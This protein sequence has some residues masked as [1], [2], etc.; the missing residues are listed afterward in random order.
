MSKTGVRRPGLH[1]A[2]SL[3]VGV[4][5]LVAVLI[6]V[7]IMDAERAETTVSAALIGIGMFAAIMG[8]AMSSV[9]LI[10]IKAYR[11]VARG[12]NAIARWTVS[13]D[14]LDAFRAG[15]ARRSAHGPE[16][17]SDYTPPEVCPHGGLDVIFVANAVMI[18]GQFFGLSNTGLVRFDALKMLRQGMLGIEFRIRYTTVHGA[19]VQR[20]QTDTILLRVPVATAALEDAERVHSHFEKVLRREIIVNPGF[21]VF[22][23]KL[24]LWTA[25]IFGMAAAL[26]YSFW[27]PSTSLENPVPEIMMG[28]GIVFAGAGLILALGAW[29]QYRRQHRRG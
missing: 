19:T 29:I 25:A 1:A 5:G 9:F 2:I 3:S 18:G 17:L 16:Y 24:G 4:G 14:E 26:G 21:W 23:I 22:R 8:L 11:S 15:D 28:G 27:S 12:E 10:G 20:Y 7:L 13:P 6:G